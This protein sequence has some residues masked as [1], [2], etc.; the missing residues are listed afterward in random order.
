MQVNSFVYAER[1]AH[2]LKFEWDESKNIIN[3]QKHNV[4]FEEAMTVFKD[5][6]AVLLYEGA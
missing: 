5:N 6:M 3:I 2:Y 4:S 1:G